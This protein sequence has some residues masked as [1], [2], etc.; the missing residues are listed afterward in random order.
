[1]AASVKTVLSWSKRDWE[2]QAKW[3]PL[4]EE[5]YRYALPHRNTFMGRGENPATAQ[6]KMEHVYDSTPMISGGA[7][8]RPHPARPDAAL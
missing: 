6:S 5:A 8:H 1:M 7:R 2:N 3:E 4:L